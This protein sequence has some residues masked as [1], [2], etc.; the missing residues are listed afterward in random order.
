[1]SIRSETVAWSLFEDESA[2][3]ADRDRWH[4]KEASQSQGAFIL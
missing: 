4:L 3:P 2:L 1:M